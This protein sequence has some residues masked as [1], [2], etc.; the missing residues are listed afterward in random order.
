MNNEIGRPV[1]SQRRLDFSEELPAVSPADK[2]FEGLF[3][4]E[5]KPRS[6]DRS[7]SD[8]TASRLTGTTIER[9]FVRSI[10]TLNG[11]ASLISGSTVIG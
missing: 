7:R 5:G 9:Q 3:A 1:V 2:H 10:S 11:V 6:E 4:S 8:A